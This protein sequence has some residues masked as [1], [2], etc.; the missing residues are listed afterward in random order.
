MDPL[1]CNSKDEGTWVHDHK[2]YPKQDL[3]TE[4]S[5]ITDMFIYLSTEYVQGHKYEPGFL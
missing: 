1:N 5:I 3:R 2:Y 4:K